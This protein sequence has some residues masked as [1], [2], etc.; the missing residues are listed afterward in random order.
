MK[1]NLKYYVKLIG[2]ATNSEIA[3]LQQ[4]LNTMDCGFSVPITGVYDKATDEAL[5]YFQ[6]E[7][8]YKFNKPIRITGKLDDPTWD[9]LETYL[10]T[11]VAQK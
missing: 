4:I 5:T 6:K 10:E 11:K 8:S 3:I 7:Y 2:G 9:L 1:K